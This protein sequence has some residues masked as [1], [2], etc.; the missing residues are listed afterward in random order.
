[1]HGAADRASALRN[2]RRVISLPSVHKDSDYL[3]LLLLLLLLLFYV[4]VSAP[5]EGV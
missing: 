3:L 4:V 5:L 2:T 1:M